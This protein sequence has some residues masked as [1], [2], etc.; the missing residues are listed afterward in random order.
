MKKLRVLVSLCIVMGMFTFCNEHAPNTHAIKKMES[1]EI[2][3][4]IIFNRS[5]TAWLFYEKH[6]YNTV[7]FDKKNREEL[8]SFL[9]NDIQKEGLSTHNYNLQRLIYAHAYY[10]DLSYDQIVQTDLD[11]THHFLLVAYHLEFGKINPKRFYN[12]WEIE[13]TPYFDIDNLQNAIATSEVKKGLQNKIPSNNI[14]KDLNKVFRS[15]TDE[16]DEYRKKVIVNME[17]ARW[18]PDNFGDYYVWVNIPEE[19]LQLVENGTVTAEHKVITG[20]IDRKTPIL[21]SVFNNLIINP[22]WTIPPTILKNDVVPKATANREYFVNNR[23]RIINKSTG[24]VV[25]IE[26][27]DPENYNSYR[28]VQASGP[29]NSLGLI[30]FNFPNDHMVY[31]HDTNNKSLFVRNDRALS[32]GCVRVEKPFE[33]AERILQI[34]GNALTRVDLDTLVARQKMKTLPLKKIVNIHQTYLTAYV[35]NGQLQTFKDVYDLDDRFYKRL[36]KK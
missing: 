33:L 26:E 7:W 14:Y 6:G 20:K 22:T 27:W 12:D 30:K 3:K 8:I 5:Y 25:N 17:R 15:L 36:K 9:L 10:E 29:L 18:L 1:V 34:E 24:K 21:S 19:K 4:D 13:K 35:K 2:T 11:F 28:Y 16:S 31:L 32:S 23:I